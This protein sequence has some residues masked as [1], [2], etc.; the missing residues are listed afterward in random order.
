MTQLASGAAVLLLIAALFFYGQWQKA[1]AV[2]VELKGQVETLTGINDQNA[3]VISGMQGLQARTA[4]L[5]RENGERNAEIQQR[6]EQYQTEL[7]NIRV[8]ESQKALAKP[9]NRGKAADDRM[10]HQLLRF[11][12]NPGEVV[13]DSRVA[14][15]GDPD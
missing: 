12:G 11:A 14:E 8:T 1:E 15:T 10:R 6:S 13:H 3:I 9:F 4:D 2:V 7:G 5:I